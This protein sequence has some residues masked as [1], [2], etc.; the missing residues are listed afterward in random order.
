MRKRRKVTE[1]WREREREDENRRELSRGLQMKTAQ[2]EQT[3]NHFPRSEGIFNSHGFI[4]NDPYDLKSHIRILELLNDVW[5]RSQRTP[6]AE[7]VSPDKI[8]SDK[9][10]KA[11]LDFF[12]LPQYGLV[13][14]CKWEAPK[15]FRQ[16][17]GTLTSHSH[18]SHAEKLAAF[19]KTLLIIG[20][21]P[22]FEATTLDDFITRSHDGEGN[23]LLGLVTETLMSATEKDSG[24]TP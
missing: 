23:T 15:V 19:Q 17:H 18:M 14:V 13:T 10:L 9:L 12:V 4:T 16:W 20:S 1:A 24:R 22:Y 11:L 6:R 7:P 5:Q 21:D 2:G 8:A 3:M